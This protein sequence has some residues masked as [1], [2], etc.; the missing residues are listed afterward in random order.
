MVE[1]LYVSSLV[2]N[3]STKSNHTEDNLRLFQAVVAEEETVYICLDALD[4]CDNDARIILFDALKRL[5]SMFRVLMTSRRSVTDFP[6]YFDPLKTLEIAASP[7][8][9]QS[10]LRE[11]IGR[12]K[13][14]SPKLMSDKL[15]ST[16]V[17]KLSQESNG[18]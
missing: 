13:R 9:V 14:L 4:E 1:M 11:N 8:D 10:F 3:L 15:E 2:N 5:P 18:L 17:S 6:E 12:D 7:I 16:I